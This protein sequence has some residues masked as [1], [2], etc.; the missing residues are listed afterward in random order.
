MQTLEKYRIDYHN[1]SHGTVPRTSF[2]RTGMPVYIMSSFLCGSRFDV[3][4]GT[5]HFLEHILVAGTK[6]YPSKKQLSGALEEL[7]GV[8]GAY[9]QQD[10]LRIIIDIAGQEDLPAGLDILDEIVNNSLFDTHVIENERGAILSEHYAK[11]SNSQ[12][13]VWE[14]YRRLFFQGTDYGRSIIGTEESIKTITSQDIA[15]YYHNVFLKAPVFVTAA[16]D[17]EHTD[18]KG[19]LDAIFNREVSP[20]S[21]HTLES[22]PVIREKK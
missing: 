22:L 5:A 4:P 20:D 8:F 14:V 3:I 12:L 10:F 9:T 13:S 18:L 21:L 17:F 11:Q 7:G 2:Q 16:G 6:K 15:N 1:D 19:K